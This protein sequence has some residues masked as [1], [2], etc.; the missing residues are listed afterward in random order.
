MR[1]ILDA[2]GGDVRL[3]RSGL[4]VVGSGELVGI[5]IDLH[6]AAELTPTVAAL[7]ALASTPSWIRG[8]SH[9][10]GHETDRLAA[11]STELNALGGHVVETEDGL[12]ITPAPLH[13]G[14]FHSYH[15][16][17]MATAGA[18][19]GLRVA[20]VSVEDIGTTGKTLPDFVGLWDRMLGSRP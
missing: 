10:R 15:D 17:R 8:V 11:L 7:A 1:Q 2:M 13:G 16:H 3:D 6:D 9:I 12:R 19:I 14:R 18:I 5:D 4:T 20:G